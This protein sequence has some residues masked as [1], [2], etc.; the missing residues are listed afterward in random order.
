MNYSDKKEAICQKYH[1]LLQLILDYG[2]GAMLLPQL[3]ALA[4]L[5]GLSPS[6]QSVG[7]AV[8]ELKDAGVLKRMTW[9]D[10]NSDLIIFCKYAYRF[11]YG[12]DS[13]S[14]SAAKRYTT[15]NRYLLQC[16][17]V[18]YL[19]KVIELRHLA[20]PAQV[21]D[22]LA[23]VRSTVFLRLPDLT[24]YF[25]SYPP[26][27]H[28]NRAEFAAQLAK[29]RERDELR[30][31]LAAHEPPPLSDSPPP[32]FPVVTVEQLHRRNIFITK[33]T[34]TTIALAL[35]DYTGTLRAE[36]LMDW[37]IDAYRW[38]RSLLP[39]HQVTFCVYT[40]DADGKTAL[41]RGLN[42][43][44][45]G[46]SYGEGRLSAQHLAPGAFK[47]G[48]QSSNVLSRWCGNVQTVS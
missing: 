46:V 20:T 15:V 33:L 18:D 7:R 10:N 30:R 41:L 9:I 29:L 3:R 6:G 12:G 1:A 28:S 16:Y 25:Q 17:K 34:E 19:I 27:A 8:R 2:N 40:P 36:R 26:F 42:A 23:A 38:V 11:F 21:A 39:A 44:R 31:R 35:F 22:Y 47:L 5:L 32:V 13:Q 43:K 24:A 37:A 14:V 45:G 48:I 4:V